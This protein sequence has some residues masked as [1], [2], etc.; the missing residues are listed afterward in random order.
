MDDASEGELEPEREERLDP[1]EDGGLELSSY[2]SY[3]SSV[4][5][6]K[7]L[8]SWSTVAG[9]RLPNSASSMCLVACG[10]TGFGDWI[11]DTESGR[12]FGISV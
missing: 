4:V 6:L 2:S 3:S 5:A 7:R 10:D 9:S 1:T 12:P 8:V 11:W